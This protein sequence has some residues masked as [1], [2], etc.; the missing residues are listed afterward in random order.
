MQIPRSN[1][2]LIAAIGVDATENE[3][4]EVWSSGFRSRPAFAEWDTT[5]PGRLSLDRCKTMLHVLGNYVLGHLQISKEEKKMHIGQ[6]LAPIGVD[7]AEI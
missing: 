7:I 6:F 4:L 1:K 2:Y 5:S 3:P